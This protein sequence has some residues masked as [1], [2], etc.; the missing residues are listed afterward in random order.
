MR[1][2][3]TEPVFRIQA[4]VRGHAPEA[5]TSLVAWLADLVRAADRSLADKK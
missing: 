1:G 3:G 2:S 4:E 5:E